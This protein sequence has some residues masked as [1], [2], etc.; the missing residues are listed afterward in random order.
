M[1]KDRFMKKEINPE[2]ISGGGQTKHER[3]SNSGIIEVIA[4]TVFCA[5]NGFL[6]YIGRGSWGLWALVGLWVV[7][8]DWGKNKD[9][10]DSA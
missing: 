9:E 2:S 3:T 4:F 6:E 8:T 5:T 1:N 7:L 10:S